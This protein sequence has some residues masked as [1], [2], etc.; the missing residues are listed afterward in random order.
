MKQA[1]LRFLDGSLVDVKYKATDTNEIY[2]EWFN[3]CNVKQTIWIKM[4]RIELNFKEYVT[5]GMVYN[6]VNKQKGY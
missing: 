6:L 3:S 5:K 4:D 2:I 1:Q